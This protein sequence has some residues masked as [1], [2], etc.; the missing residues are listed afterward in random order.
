[1]KS[2]ISQGEPQAPLTSTRVVRPRTR[3]VASCTALGSMWSSCRGKTWGEGEEAALT[4]GTRAP[5]HGWWLTRGTRAPP[6]R[7]AAH[8]GTRAPQHGWWLTRGTRAP[9]TWLVAHTGTRAPPTRLAAHMGT[10]APQHGW[11]LRPRTHKA[12]TSSPHRH[13]RGSKAP[14]CHE[15]EGI[16]ALG[17]LGKFL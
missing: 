11:W 6:T 4:R 8:M 13:P 12:R 7:L 10:R 15:G 14:F 3:R 9:P 16:A 1:M 17:P 5:Q 2:A